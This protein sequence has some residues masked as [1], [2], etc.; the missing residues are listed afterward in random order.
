MQTFVHVIPI[1]NGLKKGDAS[2]PLLLNFVLEHVFMT[3]QGSQDGLTNE[4]D[5]SAPGICR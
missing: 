3:V 4:W 1:Q 2:T 5:T